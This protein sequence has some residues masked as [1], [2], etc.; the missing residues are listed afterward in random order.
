MKIGASRRSRRLFC[1]Y[2]TLGQAKGWKPTS[3]TPPTQAFELG[4]HLLTASV[5]KTLSESGTRKLNGHSIPLAESLVLQVLSRSS[6]HISKKLD[7]FNWCSQIPAFKHSAAT[8]SQMFRILCRSKK[9]GLLW[10]DDARHLLGS[11]KQD[12]ITMDVSTLQLLLDA[13]I[14]SDNLLAAMEILDQMHDV[15][16]SLNSRIYNSVIVVLVRKN[17]LGLAVSM[18]IKLLDGSNGSGDGTAPQPL[19]CNVLLVALRRTGMKEQFKAVFLKLRENMVVLDKWGF[20]ICIHAFGCWGDMDMSLSLFKEMKDRS[21]G[22]DSHGGPDLCTYNSLI[23]VLFSVGR[24]KDAL[25]IFEELKGSGHETDAFT[26]RMVIYGCARSYRIEDAIKVFNEMQLKGFHPDTSVYNSLLDGLFKAK[27]L[28]KACQLFEKMMQDGIKA[29]CCTYNILIDGLIKNGRAIAAYTLFHDLKSKGQFVDAITYS[30]II[31]HHCREGEFEES[32][33]LVREMENRGFV[34]DLVT[35]TAMVMELYKQGRW[36]KIESLMK[37]VRDNNLLPDV[38]KWK[39]NVEALLENPARKR[40]DFTS[41]FPHKGGLKS[42]LNSLVVDNG[43]ISDSLEDPDL[44]TRL[45]I[46]DDWLPSPF[47][48]QLAEEGLSDN[49]RFP[50]FSLSKGRRVQGYTMSTFNIDMVNTYLSIFLAKG[51]LSLACKLFEIFTDEG[52]GAVTYTYNSIAS[53]FVKKGYFD[54]VWGILHDMCG[55]LCPADVAT[56]N[57]IVQNLGKMGRADLATSVLDR[58]MESGGYIDVI[59]YNTLINALGKAGRIGDAQKLFN[60]MKSSG[61]NPD[62]ITFN[63]LIEVHARAG[64]LEDA[65]EFLSMMIGVGLP[66]NHVTHTILGYLGKEEDKLCHGKASVNCNVEDIVS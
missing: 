64:R 5:V 14:K 1:S 7:F 47:M 24:A 44:G 53:S 38:L 39:A 11:M 31:L 57:V 3:P 27:K 54:E 35:I 22:S 12:G 55:K 66:P 51:N 46:G 40:K 61:V 17:Q 65:K 43:T 16:A 33:P 2:A 20:N 13:F 28:T 9:G 45:S 18:L 48:D 56:Y 25:A 23:R 63:T 6:L 59:M 41:I 42:L 36:D 52:V 58:L 21:Y 62:I 30:I 19:A 50:W 10:E 15:G 37:H 4:M 8:Y 60:Q 29:S 32:L 49:H 26:Y 34:V